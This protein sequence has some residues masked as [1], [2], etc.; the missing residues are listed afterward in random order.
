MKRTIDSDATNVI[1]RR[2]DR[3]EPFEMSQVRESSSHQAHT[4]PLVRAWRGDSRPLIRWNDT[5]ARRAP[6]RR[7]ASTVMMFGFDS[8]DLVPLDRSTNRNQRN[9]DDRARRR[10]TFGAIRQPSWRVYDR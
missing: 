7:A 4:F 1:A 6:A 9:E 2:D 8:R 3:E 5:M 10:M